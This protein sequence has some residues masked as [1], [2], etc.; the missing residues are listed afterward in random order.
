MFSLGVA[1]R[2]SG[3]S[4]T[5]PTTFL[6]ASCPVIFRCHKAGHQRRAPLLH[7]DVVTFLRTYLPFLPFSRYFLILPEPVL[8][9]AAT[10]SMYAGI[11]YFAS[12][13]FRKSNI[14]PASI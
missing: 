7:I 12:L 13:S 3:F 2:G 9:R 10:N 1:L 4:Y 8:G 11:L 6:S 14:S 5:F